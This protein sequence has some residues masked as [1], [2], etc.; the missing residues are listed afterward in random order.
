MRR[1]AALCALA[2]A[3]CTTLGPNY[4]A[5]DAA[6]LAVPEAY[7]GEGAPPAPRADLSRWWE[8]VDDSLVTRLI[9]EASAGNLDLAVAAARL[10]QTREALV[11]ARAGLVPTVGAGG[12]AGRSIGAGDDRTSF[13]LGADAS[14]EIDL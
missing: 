9:G 11:Q 1:Y 10:T 5:P 8:T 13:N 3:A 6:G 2:L 12:S 4:R 14:W 7:Y